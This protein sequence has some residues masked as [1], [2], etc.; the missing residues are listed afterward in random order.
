MRVRVYKN[1]HKDCYSVRAIEGSM[2]GIVIAHARNI[3]LKNVKYIVGEKGRERVIRE[4]QKNVHAFVEGDI[5]SMITIGTNTLNFPLHTSLPFSNGVAIT[6]NPYEYKSFVTRDH[7]VPVYESS[8]AILNDYGIF[9][10]SLG[11][12]NV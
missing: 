5:V 12:N 4:K 2:K 1:L 3:V 9:Q 8:Y 7:Q 11:D 6:Y 10:P